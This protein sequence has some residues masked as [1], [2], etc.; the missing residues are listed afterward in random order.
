MSDLLKCSPV[1]FAPFVPAPRTL[2]ARTRH[3]GLPVEADTLHLAYPELDE[4]PGRIHYGRVL[5]TGEWFSWRVQGDGETLPPPLAREV[6]A[7][8][9][10]PADELTNEL[11][12]PFLFGDGRRLPLLLGAGGGERSIGV[13]EVHGAV[14]LQ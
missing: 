5:S 9:V 14:S 4:A 11:R 12:D 7:H 6:A 1:G 8:A 13:A 2:P 10:R 3:A